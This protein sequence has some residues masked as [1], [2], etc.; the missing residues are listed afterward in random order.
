MQT[1]VDYDIDHAMHVVSVVS[2]FIGG[3]IAVL[4]GI[5]VNNDN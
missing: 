3:M 5:L 1:C 4:L 2:F